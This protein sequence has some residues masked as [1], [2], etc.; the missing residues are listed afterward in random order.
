MTSRT[1]PGAA[2][3]TVLD[4]VR[5][6]MQRRLPWW[7]HEHARCMPASRPCRGR[8]T[9]SRTVPPWESA[10]SEPTG[11]IGHECC[12]PGLGIGNVRRDHIIEL[13]LACA[14]HHVCG[15]PSGRVRALA[16]S[17]LKGRCMKNMTVPPLVTPQAAGNLS[18]LPVRNGSTRPHH[19][20]F[21]IPS[22]DTWV[23]VTNAEFLAD[24]HALAKGLMAAGIGIG[25]RV[26]IM[27]KTRYEW[28]LTDFAVW[29]AGAVSVPIYETSSACLLYTSPSPR[30]GLLS[31]MPSSA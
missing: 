10:L 15:S 4:S 21:S 28:T 16:P 29:T 6:A 11:E 30:D 18:D 20:A 2:L 19:V 14:D 17:G 25:E 9:G 1:A 12:A 22:A 31:R 7:V 13:S 5:S 27:S 23:D 26:A 3:M 8:P 24:V